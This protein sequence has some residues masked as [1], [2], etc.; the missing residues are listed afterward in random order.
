MQKHSEFKPIRSVLIPFV[1]EGPGLHA[2]EA[3]RHMDADIT[4]V[5]VVVV[6]PDQSLSVGAV[7]ARAV[8]RLLRIYGRDERVTSRSKIIVSYEP[9]DELAKFI[10]DEKPDLLCLEFESHFKALHVTTSEALTRPPCDI[11]LVKGKIPSNLN[12]VLVPVRGG[13][14]AELALRVG[15]GLQSQGVTALHLRSSDDSDAP[16]KGLER[17]L[18][19][20]PE[21][22]KQFALDGSGTREFRTFPDSFSKIVA[23]YGPGLQLARGPDRGIARRFEPS[24]A[25]ILLRADHRAHRSLDR[26]LDREHLGRDPVAVTARGLEHRVR[27]TDSSGPY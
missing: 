25:R 13:P 14:H 18:K 21:V 6:P 26:P 27:L 11:A 8:R 24:A 5:G 23:H 12:Q 9:W 17:V 20:M 7:G 15:L 10:Q 1:H 2:L 19:Q 3:A 22:Q 4:L 16:F